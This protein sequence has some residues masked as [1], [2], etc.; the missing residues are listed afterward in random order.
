[1]Y[2]SSL[3]SEFLPIETNIQEIISAAETESKENE[4]CE[5]LPNLNQTLQK[6]FNSIQGVCENF[7]F[8]GL[9]PYANVGEANTD[10]NL[11]AEGYSLCENPKFS[12]FRI[13]FGLNENPVTAKPV[14][15]KPENYEIL[16]KKLIEN[17]KDTIKEESKN[18]GKPFKIHNLHYTPGLQKIPLPM[19]YGE[20]VFLLNQMGLEETPISE[21][22]S[23]SGTFS[24]FIVSILIN[25]AF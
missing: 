12:G 8:C 15:T 5:T 6:I 23:V 14:T 24:F 25:F 13:Y 18:D 7:E 9:W 3:A 1:M 2:R 11:G 17:V 19:I 22:V 16:R 21:A 20:K 4:F 10:G